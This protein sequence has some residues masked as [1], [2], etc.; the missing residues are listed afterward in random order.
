M[1]TTD[2]RPDFTLI[3]QMA[4]CADILEE[5]A[6]LFWL[7]ILKFLTETELCSAKELPKQAGV[8]ERI[9]RKTISELDANQLISRLRSPARDI[10]QVTESGRRLVHQI[11]DSEQRFLRELRGWLSDNL[12]VERDLGE[13]DV[14]AFLRMVADWGESNARAFF[15]TVVERKPSE[16]LDSERVPASEQK[17]GNLQTK[18]WDL[19]QAI[20]RGETTGGIPSSLMLHSFVYWV[21]IQAFT[22]DP[23]RRIQSLF[24]GKDRLIALD[25]NVLLGHLVELDMWH[26]RTVPML[27]RIRHARSQ[28]DARISLV[29]LDS[30]IEEF[31][32][33]VRKVGNR[34]SQFRTTEGSDLQDIGFEKS[35]QIGIF[36]EFI[37]GWLRFGSRYARYRD[38]LFEEL[39][40]LI[41]TAG[42]DVLRADDYCVEKQSFQEK[43]ADLCGLEERRIGYGDPDRISHKMDLLAWVHRN[44]SR[45]NCVPLVW[46]YNRAFREYEAICLG[47]RAHCIDVLMLEAIFEAET[48]VGRGEIESLRDI[49]SQCQTG[50]LLEDDIEGMRRKARR[51]YEQWVDFE[52]GEVVCASA[53]EMRVTLRDRLLQQLARSQEAVFAPEVFRDGLDHIVLTGNEMSRVEAE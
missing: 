25:T 27:E 13:E 14:G 38:H 41:D 11:A 50:A 5:S 6:T 49:V 7:P 51:Y 44:R 29:I 36:L 47:T 33:A 43:K 19:V 26:E 12:R 17:D 28:G 35:K 16:E 46:T 24:E 53:A 40:E 10:V 3:G 4:F 2:S 39:G 32:Y 15:H 30:T 18:M 23:V 22:E 1:S 34:V 31:C 45:P 20:R 42:V 9:A 21:I 37:D 8:P 48:I 52:R